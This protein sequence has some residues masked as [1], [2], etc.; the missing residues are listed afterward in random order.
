M[1]FVDEPSAIARG[2]LIPTDFNATIRRERR[3]KLASLGNKNERKE[4]EK[5]G[6]EGIK[7]K[8]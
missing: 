8:K 1:P 2:S 6:D 7:A 4:S 5:L 3:T